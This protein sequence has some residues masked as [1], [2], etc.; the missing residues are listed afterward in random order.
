MKDKEDKSNP[1]RKGKQFDPAE[2]RGSLQPLKPDLTN[3]T[4]K[5]VK[6]QRRSGKEGK[7]VADR[8]KDDAELPG[9][10]YR[11]PTDGEILLEGFDKLRDRILALTSYECPSVTIKQVEDLGYVVES[12]PALFTAG[13]SLQIELRNVCDADTLVPATFCL[14]YSGQKGKAKVLPI[15]YKELIRLIDKNYT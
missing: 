7:P 12:N 15:P 6:K 2:N 3:N 13:N 1:G 10:R 8:K 14:F 5:R 4:K 11:Q 9:W